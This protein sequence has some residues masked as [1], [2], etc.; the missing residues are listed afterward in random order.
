MLHILIKIYYLTI[1]NIIIIIII[2][3]FISRIRNRKG[4]HLKG[5]LTP[6]PLATIWFKLIKYIR[7]SAKN[8]MFR[9]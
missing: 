6:P 8:N 5:Y 2:T 4:R 9:T 1:A 3:D 7:L